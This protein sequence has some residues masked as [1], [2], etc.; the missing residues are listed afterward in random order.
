MQLGDHNLVFAGAG[1]QTIMARGKYVR[2][3]EADSDVYL[4]FDGSAEIER[5]KGEQINVGSD[6]RR[7]I[8]RSAIAQTIKLTT[9]TFSQDDN[10]NSVS[11]NTTTTVDPSNNFEGVAVKNCLAA[12]SVQL[13]AGNAN[14]VRLLIKIPTSESGG[15]WLAGAGE[16]AG[17]GYFLEEGE[18]VTLGT[19]AEIWAYGAGVDVILSVLEEEII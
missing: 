5:Q 15:V 17:N 7:I 16:S 1:Q 9:S 19:T 11:V 13:V 14:R 2:I 6:N 8:V 4:Q 3:R 18:S 10:R 12:G